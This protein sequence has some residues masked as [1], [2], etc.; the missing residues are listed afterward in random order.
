MR[1]KKLPSCIDPWSWHL[2]FVKNLC[3]SKR[4]DIVLVKKGETGEAG[5]L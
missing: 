3:M 4:F 5:A 2:P 1:Y